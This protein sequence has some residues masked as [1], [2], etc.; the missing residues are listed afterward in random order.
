MFLAAWNDGVVSCP[1]GMPDAGRTAEVLGL[2]ESERP[3]VVLSF[4]YPARPVDAEQRAPE[5]WSARAKRKS[6]DE[7]VQ[8]L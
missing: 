7:L 1:N 8:R 2:D 5:E 3:L 6:L 4:G